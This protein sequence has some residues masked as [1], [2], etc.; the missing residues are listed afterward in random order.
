MRRFLIPFAAIALLFT[1]LFSGCASSALESPYR[2]TISPAEVSSS[3]ATST[4]KKMTTTTKYISTDPVKPSDTP[5]LRPEKKENVKNEYV[6][7]DVT[8]TVVENDIITFS[9]ESEPSWEGPIV[10]A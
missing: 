3:F 6:S 4:T 7:P 5:L 1:L 10:G 9:E 2:E 8:V